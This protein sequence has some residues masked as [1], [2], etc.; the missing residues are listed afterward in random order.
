MKK[1]MLF[2]IIGKS[3]SGKDTLLNS[4]LRDKEFC[5]VI[6]LH[7]LVRYTTRD[8]RSTEVDGQ[9]YHFMNDKDFHKMFY[10]NKNAVITSF[11]MEDRVVHYA[12]NF[13]TL[14]LNKVYITSGD[15]DSIEEYKKLCNLCIIYLIP[16]DY[17]VLHRF[18]KREDSSLRNYWK[19]CN[20]RYLDDLAKF[21]YHANQ[22]ISGSNC[23]I[24]VGRMNRCTGR[25][26]QN[27]FLLYYMQNFVLNGSVSVIISNKYK[28]L[29]IDTNYFPSYNVK[30]KD[31][32]NGLIHIC[33]GN[34]VIDSNN[35]RVCKN[36]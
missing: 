13:S 12:T 14:D 4:I 26:D 27:K 28:P 23:I 24:C 33:N 36:I 15:P 22:F 31:V 7:K 34:I 25:F 2:L 16:P 19:E 5:S 11:N 30:T 29:D 32:L 35:E 18:I 9:D 3:C 17:E 1:P 10:K 20:R 8:K 21:G 6:K